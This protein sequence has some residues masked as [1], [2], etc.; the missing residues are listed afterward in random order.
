MKL[1]WSNRSNPYN[2]YPYTDSLNIDELDAILQSC[3]RLLSPHNPQIHHRQPETPVQL[4]DRLVHVF[5]RQIDDWEDFYRNDYPE[6][7][8]A[9]EDM[10]GYRHAF[11]DEEDDDDHGDMDD[12]GERGTWDYR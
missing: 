3:T 7:E 12:Q 10:M 2:P 1:A 9:D 8:D 4:H 6:D 5:N 11:D